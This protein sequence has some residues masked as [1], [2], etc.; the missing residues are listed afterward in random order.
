MA[1]TVGQTVGRLTK[2][3]ELNRGIV[4]AVSGDKSLVKYKHSGTSHWVN[5][6]NLDVIEK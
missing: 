6:K 2:S 5:N 4:R 3:N 1:F